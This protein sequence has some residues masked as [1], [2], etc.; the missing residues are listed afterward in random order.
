[1]P[2]GRKLETSQDIAPGTI[3]PPV[4]FFTRV[5]ALFVKQQNP[6]LPHV[7]P[8]GTLP[9]I[10]HNSSGDESQSLLYEYWGIWYE[11]MTLFPI[12]NA[13][14]EKVIIIFFPHRR[15]NNWLWAIGAV[16]CIWDKQRCCL[17]FSA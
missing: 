2:L 15:Y 7:S 4:C 9:I 8:V 6:S 13:Y 14:D 10:S 3:M 5:A 12:T 11:T 1:M 17:C 16:I